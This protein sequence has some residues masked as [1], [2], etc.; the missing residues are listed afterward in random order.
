MDIAFIASVVKE[1]PG[2]QLD[3]RFI[4]R[5]VKSLESMDCKRGFEF[6]GNW[7]IAPFLS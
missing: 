1:S 2:E 5:R 4:A 3:P 6:E 7:L